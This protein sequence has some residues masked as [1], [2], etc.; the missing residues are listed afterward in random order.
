LYEDLIRA[1]L[2][3]WKDRISPPDLILRDF[4]VELDK[5]FSAPRKIIV[6][7][8]LRR[9]GK[10]Y[11][12]FQLLNMLKSVRRCEAA[13]LNFEDERIPSDERVLSDF[14]TV[15]KTMHE[16]LRGVF[17]FLDEIHRI[18]NWSRWLRRAYDMEK[19]NI[20]ITGSTSKM[21]ATEL[22]YELGG[23]TLTLMVFPL[24]F[25]EF[26][27]FKGVQVDM[28]I[29][30]YSESERSKLI[31]LFEEYL[32]YGG[33]PEVVLAPD[34]KKL[35]ILQ[36]YFNTIIIRDIVGGRDI[37]NISKLSTLLRML[38]NSTYFTASRMAKI[39]SSIGYKL[40][41]DIILDYVSYAQDA[42]FIDVLYQL[43][44]SFRY[45]LLAP[46]KVYV[47][48]NGF[49]TALS[50]KRAHYGRLLE[51]LVYIELKRRFFNDPA[52]EINHWKNKDKEVDFVI[53]KNF[54]V[55]RL[56][57]VCGDPS[58]HDTFTRELKGLLYLMK[59]TGKKRGIIVTGGYEETRKIGTM[60]IELIPYWK[61]E[62]TERKSK[63]SI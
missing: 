11:F 56:I 35:M 36:D 38:V 59:K 53:R 14:L 54:E 2:R 12:V 62:T 57:Q 3:E 26:L 58:D 13:Y 37:R 49:I 8:G 20:V 5:L 4:S 47:G 24:R 40:S 22:P 27:R 32:V 61:W 55:M 30:E 41:K 63:L 7:V 60:T 46:R 16:R 51:N 21:V 42:Y 19:P 52:I 17:L 48:D 50:H 44:D 23:R 18:S 25:Q 6:I 39:M 28:S 45:Q 9:V 1:L 34:F 33:L 10:T 43:S 15:L 29:A 31:N